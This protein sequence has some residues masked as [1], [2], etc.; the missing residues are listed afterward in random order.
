VRLTNTA[1]DTWLVSWLPDSRGVLV[2]QDKDGNERVQLFRVDLERPLEMIPL[3][4]ANPNYYLRGGRMHPN[5]RWLVYGANFDM[6]TGEEIEQTWI[7]RHDLASGERIPLAKPLKAG[8]TLPELSPKGTHIL[9]TRKDLHP[10]GRQV[11]LVDIEGEQDTEILNFGP[12]KKSF[13]HWFPDGRRAVVLAETKTHK[14]LGVWELES[15]SLRWLIDDPARDIEEAFVPYGSDTIVVIENIQGRTRASL[16]P[17]QGAPETRLPELGPTL[18]PLAPCQAQVW[19]GFIYGS[20]QPTELVRF[21]LANPHP[22]QFMSLTRVWQHTRLTPSDFALA[23]DFRWRSVDGLEIHGW[24]YRPKG[25]A[26]GTVIYVHGGPTWHSQ[27]WINPQIQ[28]FTSQGFNV[29][30]PNYRGSTGYG[31]PFCY[32]I[33]EDGWG[34]REQE[35]IRSG[36]EALIS[37][38]IAE[39]GKVGITGTSYGGYST[40]FAITHYPPGL[41]AAAA[42]ICGMTDLVVDYETTRPD[43][44]PYGE[45]MMGGSPAQAPERYYE[46]SPI[47]FIENIRGRL[48]IVQGEQDPN[49]TPENVRV[50]R[51]AL[52]QAGI[53]YQLLT[54]PDEGHGISKPANQRTLYL[55]LLEFFEGA[56]AG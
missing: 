15:R 26:R 25:Y 34:G 47:H 51:D 56:F 48:L 6:T 28:F 54:F 45:E 40:W 11:W 49:V 19:V 10:A 44:R 55:R 12:D 21:S 39:P 53:A 13:A 5:G 36:I 52:E 20:R 7:Y 9:Y 29:L 24:L 17:S 37:A 2:E 42:P 22:D 32:A 41:V 31:F 27:D 4:E 35:D 30:D 3:T 23:E 38:S 8:Y 14:R 33:R 18:I 1:D 50:V 43:L 16:L 46:R